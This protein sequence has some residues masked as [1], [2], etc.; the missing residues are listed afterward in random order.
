[1]TPRVVEIAGSAQRNYWRRRIENDRL[2]EA[3]A[4][5]GVRLVINPWLHVRAGYERVTVA[6]IAMLCTLTRH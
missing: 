2:I 1:M 4:E 6:M 3:A 5:V